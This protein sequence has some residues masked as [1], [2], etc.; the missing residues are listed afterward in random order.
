M[1]SDADVDGSHIRT[2]LMTFFYR[3]M[4]KLV[5]YGH[6]YVAQ[7]PLYMITSSKK[8]RRY[9]HTEDEMQ[10]TLIATGLAGASLQRSNPEDHVGEISGDQLKNLL[11]LVV[12]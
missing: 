3:Q 8:E 12:G 11:E 9:L 2:L 5:A 4:S 10:A 7:P 6:L 1:M